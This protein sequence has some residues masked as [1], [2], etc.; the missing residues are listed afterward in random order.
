MYLKAT[1]SLKQINFKVLNGL[2]E[3]LCQWYNI[4]FKAVCGESVDVNNT[5]MCNPIVLMV[6]KQVCKTRA[7]VA[8]KTDKCTGRMSEKY[9]K[10][11]LLLIY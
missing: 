4:I 11:L 10:F 3:I 7:N 5:D 2:M 9:Q 6:A 1:Q 8:L